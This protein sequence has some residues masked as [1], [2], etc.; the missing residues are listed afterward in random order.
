MAGLYI[1][2]TEEKAELWDHPGDE[3]QI[4]HLQK[5]KAYQVC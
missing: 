4:I 1:T 3:L 5:L 2:M